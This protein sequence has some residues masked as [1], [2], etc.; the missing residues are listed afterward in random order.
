MIKKLLFVCF[1]S[2]FVILCVIIGNLTPISMLQDDSE[3][4]DSDGKAEPVE[5]EDTSSE[6]SDDFA[7]V[8]YHLIV[9]CL[10]LRIYQ[11]LPPPLFIHLFLIPEISKGGNFFNS[12]A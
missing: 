6:D 10:P 1:K 7:K 11:A 8:R 2:F 9:F 3:D 5:L 12:N 4:D